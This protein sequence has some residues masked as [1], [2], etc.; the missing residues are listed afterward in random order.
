MLTRSS[1]MTDLAHHEQRFWTVAEP[2]LQLPGV[3]RSTMMGLP[4]LRVN[5]A[6]FASWDRATGALLVKLPEAEVDRLVADGKA[7]PFA[8]A[9]R[10]FREWASIPVA[11]SR[12]WPKV[13]ERAFDHVSKL[14]PTKPARRQR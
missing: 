12:A 1:P 14:P 9:G 4:C 3:T 10:R 7:D 11:R 6:F 5:E 2:L 13:L 8:P